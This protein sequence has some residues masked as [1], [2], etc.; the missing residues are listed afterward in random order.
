[1][2]KRTLHPDIKAAVDN[3]LTAAISAANYRIT[4]NTQKQ[5]AR[6]KLEKD[7]T[8]SLSGG[9]FNISPELISFVQALIFMGHK[10]F[11]MLD[12]NKNP[13][14]ISDLQD[15][16]EQIVGR[17]AECMNEFLVEFKSIQKART[18]K[19]LLGE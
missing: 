11:V 12:V 5:N 18:T 9:I 6:L 14:E 13:I 10:E 1:M 16:Q 8:F 7:L 19:A 15:F 17:Y 2:K 4:L 3:R